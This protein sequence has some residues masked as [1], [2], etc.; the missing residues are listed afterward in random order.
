MSYL[1]QSTSIV[2]I[3]KYWLN[4]QWIELQI[5]YKL[6]LLWRDPWIHIVRWEL[7]IMSYPLTA[8]ACN[9]PVLWRGL[10]NLLLSLFSYLEALMNAILCPIGLSQGKG[11]LLQ[12]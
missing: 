7:L 8:P 5:L 4:A 6:N 1:S 12:V 10:A 2:T 9:V 3:L 11:P